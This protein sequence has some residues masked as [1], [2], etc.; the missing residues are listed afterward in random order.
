[1]ALDKIPGGSESGSMGPSGE[2]A[3]QTEGAAK[4]WRG[5]WA[6]TVLEIARSV[7]DVAG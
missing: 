2:R 6:W 5:E 4:G 3:R 7:L 1:M